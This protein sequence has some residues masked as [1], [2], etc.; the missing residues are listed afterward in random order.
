MV[1]RR[2]LAIHLATRR[3]TIIFLLCCCCCLLHFL[4][5]LFALALKLIDDFL[6]DL[7]APTAIALVLGV[8][9]RRDDE[10][11]LEK[12]VGIESFDIT[13]YL[14]GELEGDVVEGESFCKAA[15]YVP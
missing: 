11:L 14:L 5:R 13:Y 9:E 3:L 6:E 2:R 7:G 15:I 8:H 1:L 12:R 10:K 4:R